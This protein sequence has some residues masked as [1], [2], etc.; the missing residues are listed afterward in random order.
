MRARGRAVEPSYRLIGISSQSY[1]TPRNFPHKSRSHSRPHLLKTYLLLGTN[2][3]LN[4]GNFTFRERFFILLYIAIIPSSFS[5][6]TLLF[7]H[8]SDD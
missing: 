3:S 6:L 4:G 8:R 1:T 7:A 2:T 5:H